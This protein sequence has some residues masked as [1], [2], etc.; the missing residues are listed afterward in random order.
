L[1]FGFF[2]RGLILNLLD[3]KRDYFQ[4]LAGAPLKGEFKERL[5]LGLGEGIWN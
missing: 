2:G 4:E 3:Y 1:A 5:G